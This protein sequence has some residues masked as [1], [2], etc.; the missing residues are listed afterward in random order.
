[1]FN[2]TT[3]AGATAAHH[4]YNLQPPSNAFEA[5]WQHYFTSTSH[6]GLLLA[7]TLLAW[8]EIVF[9][10]RFFPYYI[11]D[12][13]PYFRKYKIQDAKPNTP[14][15]YWKCL[16]SVIK[17]QLFVQ[18]PMMLLFHPTA[19]ALGMKF[20]DPFP[21]WQTLVLSCLFCLVVEDT[22]HYF[23]HRLMHRP[24]LYKYV[25]KVHHEFSAPFGITA[26]HAH[27]V[28]VLVLG[29][30]FFI[31]PVVLL[32][33]GVDVHVITI[34]AWIAL[35]LLETVDVHA[36][37]D[38]PWSFHKIIPF[39]GGA[40][41]HDYHHMAFVGNYSSTFRHWDIVFGTDKK[42]NEWKAKTKAIKAKAASAASAAASRI[43][44]E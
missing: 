9:F 20:L 30:G 1:M 15:L 42:F 44:S 18:G 27:P 19:M 40:E 36:G 3:G 24:E 26:E 35:R 43:K 17:S 4:P 6:P 34:A 28:E 23:V 37:Y 2:A 16:V 33:C 32:A 12:K 11:M 13:I 8:H 38:F 31:G 14:E 10:G 29:Q 5:Y 25:H 22:Y 7:V 41:F 21:R 39:Y